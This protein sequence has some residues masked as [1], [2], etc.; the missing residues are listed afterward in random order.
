MLNKDILNRKKK[1]KK[2]L[3]NDSIIIIFNP[4]D[5][6]YFTGFYSSSSVIVFTSKN[7]YYYT[8]A[9]YYNN[10]KKNINDYEIVLIEK[11]N[12]DFLKDFNKY[13]NIFI[14]FNHVNLLILNK[15]K[16]FFNNDFIDISSVINEIRAVKSKSE[17]NKISKASKFSI[18]LFNNVINNKVYNNVSEESLSQY[19]IK[20]S[21][22]YDYSGVAFKPIVAYDKNA[23]NPHY[24]S[25]N[26]KFPNQ[27]ILIDM[28][29]SYKKYK[30]DLTRTILFNNIKPNKLKYYYSIVEEAYSQTIE[31]IKP[32]VLVSD[33]DKEVRTVFKK[34][35]VEDLFLHATGHGI[36]LEEHEYPRISKFCDYVLKENNVIAIEPGLYIPNIGGIRIENTIAITNKGYKELT[37]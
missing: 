13:K 9:R 22:N 1:L 25:G 11:K 21:F 37:V 18:D 16:K 29:L 33:I 31:K 27:E 28:G 7:D 36:G 12:S 19:I 6:F 23:I 24:E 4:I 2:I 35:D 34:Y 14:E 5:S 8:D 17:I 10:A 30:S 3:N 32:G 26:K 20:N 15:L